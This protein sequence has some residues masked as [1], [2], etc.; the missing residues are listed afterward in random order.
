MKSD[1]ADGHLD[2]VGMPG[3]RRQVWCDLAPG[4]SGDCVK[5]TSCWQ[6]H[7][8]KLC[9]LMAAFTGLNSDRTL[10]EFTKLPG[11]KRSPDKTV[12][13]GKNFASRGKNEIRSSSDTHSDNPI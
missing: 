5:L 10:A 2:T 13:T 3:I 6:F 9:N 12:W 11:A 7:L 4:K 8:L 1:V